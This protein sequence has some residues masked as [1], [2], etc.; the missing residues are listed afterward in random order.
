[1]FVFPLYYFDRDIKILFKMPII[2]PKTRNEHMLCT[3]C[4]FSQ[5][6][7]RH[8][9]QP[10][11]LITRPPKRENKERIREGDSLGVRTSTSFR[12]APNTFPPFRCDDLSQCG[13]QLPH[14]LSP[15]TELPAYTPTIPHLPRPKKRF[16]V[17]YRI[18]CPRRLA[19]NEVLSHLVTPSRHLPSPSRHTPP[20]LSRKTGLP[21]ASQH[22]GYARALSFK[23]LDS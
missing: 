17:V 12:Q 16:L 20:P 5:S 11:I 8:T 14:S 3:A 23:P 6:W 21:A 15:L 22:A 4:D 18:R 13:H 7:L 1:M 9:A 19:R 10:C 2:R